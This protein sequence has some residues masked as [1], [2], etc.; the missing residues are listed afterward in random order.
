MHTSSCGSM[1]SSHLK[2]SA[3]GESRVRYCELLAI[4]GE[5]GG[6]C[7]YPMIALGQKTA[8][9]NQVSLWSSLSVSRRHSHCPQTTSSN[10]PPTA[11]PHRNRMHRAR[12]TC[13]LACGAT[14]CG[15]CRWRTCSRRGLESQC[16]GTSGGR[17]CRRWRAYLAVVLLMQPVL[18]WG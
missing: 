6:E 3:C 14:F 8:A 10:T 17:R 1:P 5:E 2:R 11:V 18:S 13:R 9:H 15:G 16:W 4:A 12:E 7:R